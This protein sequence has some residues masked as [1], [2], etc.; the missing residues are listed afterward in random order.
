MSFGTPLKMWAGCLLPASLC[1]VLPISTFQFIVTFEPPNRMAMVAE[2]VLAAK[3]E[4]PAACQIWQWTRSIIFAAKAAVGT[5]CYVKYEPIAPCQLNSPTSLFLYQSHKNRVHVA[6]FTSGMH[7]PVEHNNFQ[8]LTHCLAHTQTA[9][10][11]NVAW[12]HNLL[13]SSTLPL[14]QSTSYLCFKLLTVNCLLLNSTHVTTY[15]QTTE[16]VATSDKDTAATKQEH[17]KQIT[18]LSKVSQA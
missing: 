12:L 9:L 8:V 10:C 5:E 11:R 6:M 7:L 17:S 14:L 1:G 3:Q 15:Q 18:L 16:V 2:G 4:P 13:Y